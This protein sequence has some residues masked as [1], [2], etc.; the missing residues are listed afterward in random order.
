V[1]SSWRSCEWKI[2]SCRAKLQSRVKA[3]KAIELE[4]AKLKQNFEKSEQ[5]RKQ[6]KALL[7]VYRAKLKKANRNWLMGMTSMLDVSFNVPI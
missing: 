5:I 2:G 3:L 4:Y 7:E 1:V 6:Q